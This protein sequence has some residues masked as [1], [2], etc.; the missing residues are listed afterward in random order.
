MLEDTLLQI[1]TAIQFGEDAE[2]VVP[3]DNPPDVD[4]YV[5]S[6]L[7]PHAM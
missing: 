1:D 2:P 4:D 7:D 5:A 3:S 6:D